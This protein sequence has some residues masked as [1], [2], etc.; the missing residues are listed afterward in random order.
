MARV[1][2]HFTLTFL[3][4]SCSAFGQ[5]D[6]KKIKEQAELTAKSLLQDDYE[7]LLRFTHPKVI[8][9]VGDETEW[10]PL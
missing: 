7:T 4:I 6:D 10:F 8:E 2:I 1:R 9:L 3:L 5:V